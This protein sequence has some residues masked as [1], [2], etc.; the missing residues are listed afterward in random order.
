MNNFLPKLVQRKVS[1]LLEHCD[2]A[3]IFITKHAENVT[4]SY[5]WGA[6]NWYA[7]DG[8]VRGWIQQ[9]D[10]GCRIDTRNDNE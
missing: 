6:G 5:T 8:Q 3:Q 7:R 9:N 2:S 1:E 4:Q 10:E